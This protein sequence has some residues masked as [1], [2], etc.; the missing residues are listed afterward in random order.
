MVNLIQAWAERYREIYPTVSVQVAGGGSGVGFAGLVDGILDIAAASREITA[1]ESRRVQARRGVSPR[2][3]TVALDAIAVYAHAANPLNAISLQDLA[4]IYGEGGRLREWSQ[5]GI[6]NSACRHD[7]IIR[8]GRQSNSG[9]YVYFGQVVLGRARDYEM[10]SIDLSG[11]KDVVTLVSRTPCAIGYS[12]VAYAMDGGVKVLA[13]ATSGGGP[14]VTPSVATVV[15]GSYPIARPLYFYTAGAPAGSIKD[16][17]HW[18]LEP[19]GQKIVQELGF[20]PVAEVV[21]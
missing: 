1:D 9:T 10:G 13:V 20:V 12:G 5:L 11:S 15:G 14:A 3:V 7:E 16:F 19:D 8:V 18:V 4:E 2:E 6:R 17:L 21:P